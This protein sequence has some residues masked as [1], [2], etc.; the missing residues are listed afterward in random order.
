A[1]TSAIIL[2]IV[3]FAA[4]F[5]Y[6]LTMN[7]VPHK[8]GHFLTTAS[9]SPI[10][11]LLLVNLALFVV[12]M[13]METLAAIIILAPILAPAAIQ[14]GIDPIQ[15]GAIMI[16]NLAVGMVTPPVGINLFVV[17][18]VA[19]VRLEQLVRP[20]L[21][22]LGVLVVNILIISYVPALTTW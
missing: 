13:L 1:V 21:I 3:A 19:N 8:L 12:G 7:Q 20:L 14:F 18:Q 22:F 15:F 17:C 2:V 9:D 6:I 10:F 16:V 11:F 4:I 5:A